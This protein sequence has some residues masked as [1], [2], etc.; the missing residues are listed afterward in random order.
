MTDSRGSRLTCFS[1]I[2][3]NYDPERSAQ[4]ETYGEV[5]VHRELPLAVLP[6]TLSILCSMGG[7]LT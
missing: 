5:L 7:C 3:V 1:E 4:Y 2:R 6:C